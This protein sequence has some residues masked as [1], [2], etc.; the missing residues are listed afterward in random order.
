M[1]VTDIE[2]WTELGRAHRE[3]FGEHHPTMTMV[4]VRRLAPDMLIEIGA[5]AVAAER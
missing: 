4:K 1:F 5:D 3:P 2:R